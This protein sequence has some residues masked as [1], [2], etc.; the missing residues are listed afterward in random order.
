M[1]C[2]VIAT[3]FRPNRII[4]KPRE[5]VLGYPDHYQN[6]CSPHDALD[7]IK[8]VISFELGQN[9]GEKL[10]I[11]IVNSDCGFEEGNEYLKKIDGT[12]TN[13]GTIKVLTKPDNIGWSFG[14]FNY[15]Y[16]CLRN[17]YNYWMF[18]EDDILIGGDKYYFKAMEKLNEKNDNAFVAMVKV[19]KHSYGTHAGGGIGL[20][21]NIFLEKV[22]EKY[23][24]LPHFRLKDND[25][26]DTHKRRQNIIREGEVPFSNVYIEMGFNIVPFG[27]EVEWDLEKNSVIP[28]YDYKYGK[29]LYK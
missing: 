10:D 28:Y 29:Q 13:Y 20:T 6:I 15:A 4:R 27:N 22:Y 19:C 21:K 1:N 16:E 2:K 11:V 14:A 3:S 9:P 5:M 8:D 18:T 25:K 26:D 12:Q 17:R 23:G 7:L 24:N